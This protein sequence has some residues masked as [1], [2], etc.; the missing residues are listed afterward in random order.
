MYIDFVS[1]NFIEV[2]CFNSFLVEPFGV[3]IRSYHLQTMTILLLPP[4]L[5]ASYFFCCLIAVARTSNMVLDR[6]G[7]SGHPCLVFDL[8]RKAL[9]S[10][11]FSMM[12][13]ADLP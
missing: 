1:C 9:S 8:K 5:D 6:S 7:E 11:L 10:S 12:S 13:S 2:V 3:S 4:K